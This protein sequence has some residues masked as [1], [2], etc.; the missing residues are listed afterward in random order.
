MKRHLTA[1]GAAALLSLALGTT[2]SAQN[3]VITNARVLDGTGK[4]IENGTIIARDGRIASVT[5]GPPSAAAVRGLQRIDAKGMTVLPGF[6]DAHRHIIAGEA[7]KWLADEAPASMKSFL[8]G[9]FTTVFSMGDDAK[10]ILEL[11]SRLNSGAIVGPRLY[12]ASMMLLAK[13]FPAPSVAPAP[14]QYRDPGRTDPARTP[15]RPV[16]PPEALPDEAL[17]GMVAGAKQQGF[18]AIKTILIESPGGPEAHALG[19]VVDEAHKQGLRVYTHATHYLDTLAAVNAKVDVLAHTPHIGQLE[20]NTP[21]VERIAKSG[22]PMVSTLQV[23]MPHFDERNEPLYRDGGPF[24]MP[25]AL[26]SAGQGPVNARLLSDAGTVY[27]YG[28]DTNWDPRVSLM[29]ELRGLSLT[30]S[31]RDILKI[32]GPNT[33][34]A[35]NKSADLGTLEAGKIADIVI[36]AGDPLDDIYAL[37]HVVAVV[38]DGKL[39]VNK[40]PK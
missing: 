2:A 30:F 6:I 4:A 11:R 12:A 37:T 17:R 22:I 23:F 21:A 38:K 1:L 14:S 40:M 19:V 39:V 35:I 9:G 10:G 34:A 25:R 3:L 31:Q 7:T 15:T 29:D 16:A 13:G 20:E 5:A 18:D 27:A 8:E 32:M 36:V 28:T 26:S 24:P 33:A